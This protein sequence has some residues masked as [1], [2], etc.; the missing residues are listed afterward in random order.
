MLPCTSSNLTS[1]FNAF[2]FLYIDIFLSYSYIL[3]RVF[4]CRLNETSANIAYNFWYFPS[5]SVI[6]CKH[7]SSVRN[8][9]LY[10]IHNKILYLPLHYISNLQ[11]TIIIISF[12]LL[13]LTAIGLSLGGSGYFTCI[14][15][16]ELV[17]NKFKSGR[18][19]EKLVVAIWNVGNHLI[20][21]L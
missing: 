19:Y 2:I 16:M 4:Y 7:N 14:Q 17:T 1:R 6:A 12:L 11:Q 13:L 8:T 5:R 18:L 15:N 10:F 20:V 3:T 21:C 9:T